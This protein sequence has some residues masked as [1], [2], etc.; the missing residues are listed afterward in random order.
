VIV[1]FYFILEEET[2]G[3]QM[4]AT[5]CRDK[6]VRL[7]HLAKAQTVAT[8]KLPSSGGTYTRQ[9]SEEH[10]GKLRVWTA[11]CWPHA[12]QLVTSGLR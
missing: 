6:T 9:R 11:L 10:A 2:D 12:E 5:S 1:L 3:D 4:L 7:W 8:L